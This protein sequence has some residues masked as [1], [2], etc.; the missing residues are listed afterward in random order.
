MKQRML[1]LSCAF[2][3]M[4][5]AIGC[6]HP[7]QVPPAH[8]GKLKTPSG[9]QEDLISPSKFRLN[10]LCVT[11]DDLVIA[12]SSDYGA[13]EGMKI[14]MPS[15]K[16]NL[17]V[18]VRGTFSISDNPE[19]MKKI[20]DRVPA[21]A[22][23]D[24]RVTI[25]SLAKVYQIYAQPILR[26]T[27]RSIMTRYTIE[28]IMSNREKISNELTAAVKSKLDATP[29]TVIYFGLADIQPPKVI[30]AAQEAAKEREIAIQKAEADKLVK[31]KEAE[32][33]L[34]VA[35]K[36]Q[37]V[38]LKEAETQVM[39]NNKLA[40]G[41]TA[42]FVAQ[43]SLKVLDRMAQNPNTVFFLPME[44]MSNPAMIM[45]PMQNSLKNRK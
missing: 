35:V 18:E 28:E 12:E 1:L 26:E 22:T 23:D 42:A 45:G 7:V 10:F 11:C 32:A 39:V 25:I 38:D 27:V 5:T 30:V 19:N 20:F 6:G 3:A 43:R 13:R 4:F 34:E 29:I 36:Q 2:L 33:A 14:F 31:L 9:L 21:E 17:D 41:V 44:A 24:S 8:V 16:L 15:D 40:E 37:Q